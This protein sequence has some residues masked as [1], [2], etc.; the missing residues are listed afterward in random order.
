MVKQGIIKENK[1]YFQYSNDYLF[2][3]EVNCVKSQK[4]LLNLKKCYFLILNSHFRFYSLNNF[5]KYKELSL[6][7]TS[8]PLFYLLSIVII[9][10]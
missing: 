1:R 2:C 8:K 3:F 7:N 4:K 10:R 5:M 9:N 6:K